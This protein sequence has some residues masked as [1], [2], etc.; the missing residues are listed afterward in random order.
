LTATPSFPKII[1][2][3]GASGY[4]PENTMVAFEKAISLGCDMI[5]VD[6]RP[7]ADHRAV[8]YHDRRLKRTTGLPGSVRKFTES[9][10]TA[11][12]AAYRYAIPGYEDQKIP[13]LDQ[14]L[15]ALQGRCSLLLEIKAEGLIAPVDF[16]RFVG[17][18]LN[19][20]NGDQWVT[21]QSFDSGL[22]RRFHR[23]FP[24]Y[25][26]HKLLVFRLPIFNVQLDRSLKVE[27]A[28]K[29]SYY[30][31]INVDHR[32]LSPRFIKKVHRFG[33]EVYCW[34]VNDKIRMKKLVEWQIDGIITN[35]PDR[36]LA[37]RE[38]ENG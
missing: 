19:K 3:R 4:A 8:I 37:L 5:E 21:V 16:L 17:E 28:L 34:T 12:P 36:L 14:M 20:Y 35:Y 23:M 32:F 31:A 38:N 11:L 27:D 13:S 29:N 7:T 22:L 26:I 6:V 1:A 18:T 15:S 30:R 25:S 9:Q 24:E 2:H 33:K 10:L